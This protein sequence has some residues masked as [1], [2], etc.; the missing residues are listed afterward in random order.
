MDRLAR[1]WL[2]A[3][4]RL[5]P[6][7]RPGAP[8]GQLLAL[9]ARYLEDP[10][11]TAGLNPRQSAKLARALAAA[12]GR[13]GW[14]RRDTIDYVLALATLRL[15]HGRPTLYVNNIGSS[16]SHWLLAM[17]RDGVGLLGTG[18]IYVPERF[19][20]ARIDPA[21]TPGKAVFLQSV[22]L[23]HLMTGTAADLESP[24]CN[25]AHLADIDAYARNDLPSRRVLL[26][27]DP[28]EIALSRTL[29]KPGFRRYL[30]REGADDASYLREN[31]ALVGRFFRDA[32]PGAYDLV[33]R[34]EDLL[35]DPRPALAAAARLV[36]VAADPARLDRAARRARRE[37]APGPVPDTAPAT[38]PG[39]LREIAERELAA[40]RRKLGYA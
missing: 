8:L 32:E 25:T 7:R 13:L 4:A 19:L 21:G 20:R 38:A 31:A 5:A 17:L 22:Y 26:V 12:E 2:G 37:E 33:L 10:A 18:E 9:A 30:G 1:L 24:L 6:P 16:G 11:A 35:A 34:Y 39:A 23:A 36:G 27:R 14:S 3:R 40:A 28:V 29:R 15:R